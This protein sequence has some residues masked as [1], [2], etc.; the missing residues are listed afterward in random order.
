MGR[1]PSN[2]VGSPIDAPFFRGGKGRLCAVSSDQWRH[3]YAQQLVARLWSVLPDGVTH[4][5]LA[6][7]TGFHAETVRR[8]MK[9][10]TTPP[11]DFVASVCHAFQLDCSHV[12]GV[13][14]GWVVAVPLDTQERVRLAARIGAAALKELVRGNGALAVPLPESRSDLDLGPDS[15]SDSDPDRGPGGGPTPGGPWPNGPS[16]PGALGSDGTP[17]VEVRPSASGD[18]PELAPRP[19]NERNGKDGLYRG[20]SNERSVARRSM[21]GDGGRGHDHAE[22]H[23]AFKNADCPP[24]RVGASVRVDRAC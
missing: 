7:R 18:G 5:E 3:E 2:T 16:Q 11:A 6:R 12:F 21:Q 24:E 14:E 4:A 9:A 15:N 8:Y 19:P 20:P 17:I 1:S 10:S 13:G 23:D 22:E